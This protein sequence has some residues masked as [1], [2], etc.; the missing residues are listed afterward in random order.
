MFHQ[1]EPAVSFIFEGLTLPIVWYS[2]K[3]L[4]YSIVCLPGQ[5]SLGRLC[6]ESRELLFT[7]GVPELFVPRRY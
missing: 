1:W 3:Y 4:T 5:Q 7:G 6:M 2:K